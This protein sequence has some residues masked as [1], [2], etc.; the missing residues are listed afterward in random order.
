[1]NRFF[2]KAALL[3]VSAS[4]PLIALAWTPYGPPVGPEGGFPGPAGESVPLPSRAM[5]GHSMPGQVKMTQE[6]TET[7]YVLLIE[8]DGLT[9]ENVEVRA[10]GRTLLVRTRMDA[11]RSR[12]E[13]FDDGRGYRES[14]QFSTGSRVR[15]FPVPP[16]GDLGGLQ[17]ED[18]AEAVRI[19]IPRRAAS[20]GQ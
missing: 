11:R 5:P 19:L 14:Y 2:L 12:S 18:T 7:D 1:M 17:R 10:S 3:F 15:R 6:R 20:P 13:T 16:D 8:L 9:P 4:V